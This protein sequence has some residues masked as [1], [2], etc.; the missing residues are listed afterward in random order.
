MASALMADEPCHSAKRAD[1]CTLSALQVRAGV[2]QD[3]Q[4]KQQEQ[5][6][7]Q[8]QQQQQHQQQ[9]HTATAA[10]T[11][12]T[13]AAKRMDDIISNAGG[14]STPANPSDIDAKESREAMMPN[15]TLGGPLRSQDALTM[16]RIAE[17]IKTVTNSLLPRMVY[18]MDDYMEDDKSTGLGAARG[19]GSKVRE[20]A[21]KVVPQLLLLGLGVGNFE[22]KAAKADG[23]LE[24]DDARRAYEG[25]SSVF[26]L[27][28]R[29]SAGLMD[30]IY[31][32]T[33][34]PMPKLDETSQNRIEEITIFLRSEQMKLT[35]E[36][37]SLWDAFKLKATPQVENLIRKGGRLDHH[38]QSESP[39]DVASCSEEAGL[40]TAALTGAGK[41][42]TYATVDCNRTEG[43]DPVECASS[44]SSIF[45]HLG[46]FVGSGT[47][48]MFDCLGVDVACFSSIARAYA[49]TM[50]ALTLTVSLTAT[51]DH[52]AK[53]REHC[54]TS[55]LE[56]VSNLAKASHILHSA[57]HRCDKRAARTKKAV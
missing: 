56:A 57:R 51:C 17:G 4:Q 37:Q 53:D 39:P 43:S 2:E 33:A 5:Q 18:L 10:A 1:G 29:R 38:Q 32:I 6:E 34:N 45:V 41:Y 50:R 7:E 12:T 19:I 9:Q 30:I 16:Y 28:H 23:K 11:R 15:A 31:S 49:K 3:L 26:N 42:L 21:Q 44:L 35:R 52:Q 24:D 8:Q 40:T 14:E 47:S 48:G 20:L 46:N 22:V 36:S 55:A 13:A 54:K 25:I 27:L